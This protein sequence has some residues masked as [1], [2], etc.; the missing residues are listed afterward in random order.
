VR[1]LYNIYGCVEKSQ[2]YSYASDYVIKHYHEIKKDR[3][4]NSKSIAKYLNGISKEYGIVVQNREDFVRFLVSLFCVYDIIIKVY[5][6]RVCKDF[7]M[8]KENMLDV[9]ISLNEGRFFD[10]FYN[11][12]LLTPFSFYMDFWDIIVGDVISLYNSI[13]LDNSLGGIYQD[14]VSKHIRRILGE[15]YTPEKLVDFVLDKVLQ[16]DGNWVE[17]RFLDP[18]CG[19]GVFLLSVLRRIKSKWHNVGDVAYFVSHNLY[20]FE[21]NP[22]AVATVKVQM[23]KELIDLNVECRLNVYNVDFLNRFQTT[24]DMFSTFEAAV[25]PFIGMIMLPFGVD[26][27]KAFLIFQSFSSDTD[28]LY[29]QYIKSMH[30]KLESIKAHSFVMY[31][32]IRQEIDGYLHMKYAGCFDYVVGNPPWYNINYLNEGDRLRLLSLAAKYN[33]LHEDRAINNVGLDVSSLVT[34]IAMDRYLC[35]DGH[36]ALV[37]PDILFKSAKSSIPFRRGLLSGEVELRALYDIRERSVFRD[38][39]INPFVLFVRKHKSADK[40]YKYIIC[41]GTTEKVLDGDVISDNYMFVAKSTG[42]IADR[43][44][45]QAYAGMH[46]KNLHGVIVMRVLQE[47]DDK[48]VL[49][50][51]EY[52]NSRKPLPRIEQMIEKDILF[53][54]INGRDI[55]AWRV[56]VKNKV[57]LPY[58]F[59]NKRKMSREE[60]KRVYPLAYEYLVKMSEYLGIDAFER[61][62]RPVQK[63]MIPG[64]KVIW[65]DVGKDIKAAVIH[66][67]EEQMLI[68]THA[69]VAINADSFEEACYVCA[70]LNSDKVKNILRETVVKHINPANISYVGLKKY[71]VSNPEHIRLMQVGKDNIN[72]FA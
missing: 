9:F 1:L 11:S 16:D 10:N 50:A 54:L 18:T 58:D 6:L 68:F 42:S 62:L 41:D 13:S 65:R 15:Y 55:D 39:S 5:A 36:M 59:V 24:V 61:M 31:N 45:Y 63:M 8:H 46:L 21:L 69:V 22:L 66:V 29:G 72:R 2:D 40:T 25:H 12:S 35:E 30:E 3:F 32:V 47:I 43:S 23:I 20:G 60:I 27:D 71:D 48:H 56:S 28:D 51:N 26:K 37:L 53:D 64:Y 14:L 38:A 57:L 34:Y 49:V 4:L 70:Y 52:K 7:V 17:K 19:D 44:D 33:L 67:S